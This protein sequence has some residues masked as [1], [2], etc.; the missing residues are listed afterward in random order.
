MAIGKR[1]HWCNMEWSCQA[2]HATSSTPTQ[3]SRGEFNQYTLLTWL[4][5]VEVQAKP[6]D[7][8]MVIDKPAKP[9]A[10]SSKHPDNVDIVDGELIY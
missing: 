3:G 9:V 8:A 1:Y 6:L 5:D 10:G 7:D 2:G 4:S